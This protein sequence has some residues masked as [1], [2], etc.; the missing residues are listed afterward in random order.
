MEGAFDAEPTVESVWVVMLNTKFRPIGR[1]RVGSGI[2]NSCLVHP[3]E[4]FRPAIMTA[5]AKIVLVHNHP[6]GDPQ[7]SASDMVVT[8][9]INEAGK[10]LQIELTDHIII[11]HTAD[12]PQGLG[13]YSFRSAGVIL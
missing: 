13:Y 3:R 1:T 6:S 11:G 9:T 5:A 10:V 12:D 2:L 7:P 4:V 8:R